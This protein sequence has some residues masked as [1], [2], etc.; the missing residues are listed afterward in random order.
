[1]MEVICSSETLVL[2]RATWRNV[3]EDGIL[4][5]L[6]VPSSE[7]PPKIKPNSLKDNFKDKE[8][9][10]TGPRLWHETRTDWPTDHWLLDDFDFGMDCPVI[11]VSSFQR[12]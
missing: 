10:E 7:R 11:E 8:N 1:M 4:H 2:T 3:P 6:S 9:P 5:N 12:T